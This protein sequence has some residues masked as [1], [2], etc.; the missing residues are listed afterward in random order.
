MRLVAL[1]SFIDPL[2]RTKYIN[3]GKGSHALVYEAQRRIGGYP[4]RYKDGYGISLARG[5]GCSTGITYW[6]SESDFNKFNSFE[7]VEEQ[8]TAGF[9][10]IRIGGDAPSRLHKKYAEALKEA[11]RLGEVMRDDKFLVVEIKA[12]VSSPTIELTVTEF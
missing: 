8:K 3:I 7:E 11:K 9:Y 6:I 4:F 2:S 1:G 12:H 5:R 10:V